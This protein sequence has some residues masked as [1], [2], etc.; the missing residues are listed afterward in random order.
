MA[1]FRREARS[2][3]MLAIIM[4]VGSLVLALIVPPFIHLPLLLL[5]E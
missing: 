1:M 2:M 5:G 4:P 3:M